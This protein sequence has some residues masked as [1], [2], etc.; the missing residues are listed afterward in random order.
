MLEQ[1]FPQLS[2]ETRAE[3]A[4]RT[5]GYT[6]EEVIAAAREHERTGAL[7][8]SL[9][10]RRQLAI[11]PDGAAME[12]LFEPRALAQLLRD[13]GFRARAYGYWGGASGASPI[14]AAN[15]LLTALS[16]LTMPTAPS[17]RVIASK[18]SSAA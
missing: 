16:P 17:F 12:E 10:Q 4:R 5:A 13:R 11:A 6:G 18:R 3:L 8:D 9:Y 2:P 15:R 7:P 14:R 1:S